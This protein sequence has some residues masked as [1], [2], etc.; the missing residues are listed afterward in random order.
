MYNVVYNPAAGG[1]KTLEALDKLKTLFKKY[2]NE[3]VVHESKTKEE[4]RFAVRRLSSTGKETEIIAVGGDG[5]L[6]D[7]LGAI[8][9]FSNVK[10]GII[11]AGTGNDFASAAGISED[12]EEAA[13]LI[14]F[15]EAK[16]T[17][18][19]EIGGVRCMNSGGLGIDSDVLARYAKCKKR[20]KLT[21]Y[22]C[23]LKSLARYK[24]V[25][26]EADV[27]GQTIRC[28]AYVAVACNGGMFGGG[29][30][31]CPAAKLDGG[32]AEVVIVRYVKGL[33]KA[34]ALAMLM[35]GKILEHPATMRF[36]TER[37]KIVCETPSVLQLDGELYS[38]LEFDAKVCGGLKLY[39]A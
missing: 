3:Y 15:G 12:V 37:V 38:G 6:H 21:Y 1:R 14:F 8:E 18:F 4:L 10:L 22:K 35:K 7:V 28:R 11:P 13:K 30:P 32:K 39:R 34:K 2:E 20:N 25:T 29:I 9:D 19:L 5:T 17:D 26:I 16:D 36:S 24:G 31:I 27:G 23:L 33:K